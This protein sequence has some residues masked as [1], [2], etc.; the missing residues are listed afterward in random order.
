MTPVDLQIKRSVVSRINF[1]NRVSLDHIK[2]QLRRI[3]AT[4]Q[5]TI[6]VSRGGINTVTFVAENDL[7]GHTNIELQFDTPTIP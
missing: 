7:N 3:R 4:G 1:P 6:N 5:L 2:R